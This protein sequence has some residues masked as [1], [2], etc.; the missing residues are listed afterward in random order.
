MY[1]P[2]L[3]V[4][5]NR[6]KP[7]LVKTKTKKLQKNIHNLPLNYRR[8][9]LYTPYLDIYPP[10]PIP[11]PTP[12]LEPTPTLEPHIEKKIYNDLN[13]YKN[14]YYH[15]DTIDYKN[16]LVSKY[17]DEFNNRIKKIIADEKTKQH[18]I[19][20]LDLHSFPKGSF[21]GAQIVI[22]DIYKIHRVKL[23]KFAI[24][25][26]NKMHIDIRIFNGLDNYIQNTYK[27]STYPLL[28]EFCEDRTYLLN[29]TIKLFFE[30]VINYF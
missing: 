6:I 9:K 8:T 29:E 25:I 14:D 1:V 18:K 11:E 21:G 19:L 20:L 5:F 26:I 23:D 15:D 7:K 27:K 30:E 2:K 16:N 3:D 24:Y 17:W 28:L 10:N 12:I 22:I 4:D 13:Y